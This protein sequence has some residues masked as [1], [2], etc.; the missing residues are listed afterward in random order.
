MVVVKCRMGYVTL[1]DGR[2]V[3]LRKLSP[4]YG[5]IA[6]GKLLETLG[7]PPMGT[8]DYVVRAADRPQFIYDLSLIAQVDLRKKG[9]GEWLDTLLARLTGYQLEV[10]RL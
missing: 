2:Q 8:G 6:V 3:L 5:G 1:L 7:I 4:A 9:H 10:E